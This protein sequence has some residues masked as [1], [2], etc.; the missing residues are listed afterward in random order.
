MKLIKFLFG[1]IFTLLIICFV[2]VGVVL[3]LVIDNNFNEPE[4][5]ANSEVVELN[6][7]EV[8]SYGLKDTKNTKK[9]NLSLDEK[10][11]SII[12]KSTAI[13]LN[14]RLAPMGVN[15]KTMYVDVD[16]NNNLKLT[17]YFSVAF[18]NSSL[19]GDLTYELKDG[20]FIFNINKVSVGKISTTMRIITIFSSEEEANRVINGH[21]KDSNM[22]FNINSDSV[23]IS[24]ELSTLKELLLNSMDGN[25]EVG[26]YNAFISLLLRVDNLLGLA[27]EQDKIGVAFDVDRLSLD[28]N[29]DMAIPYTI[30]FKS[31]SD[32]VESLLNNNVITLE[33]ISMV[34][35][36]IVKGYDKLDDES[37]D[38]VKDIDLSSVGINDNTMH[39]GIIDYKKDSVTDIFIDQIKTPFNGFRLTE[40]NWN[41]IL[42]QNDLIGQMSCFARKESDGYK[43]SY[44]SVESVYVD[45]KEDILHLY[46]TLSL[47]GQSIVLNIAI[48]T[49]NSFDLLVEGDIKSAR[50]G[51]IELNEEEIKSILSYLK[52]TTSEQWIIIDDEN[53]KISFD[54]AAVISPNE[55]LQQ[56]VA[57]FGVKMKTTFNKDENGGYVLIVNK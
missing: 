40:E 36:F 52:F 1:L 42:L 3:F 14:E 7:D 27:N 20:N 48:D 33:D 55:K 45:I 2:A 34:A 41:D 53:S 16:E 30:N 12:L 39:E 4:Y 13:K 50:L 8:L 38:K 43:I 24:I 9:L 5:L 25:E 11:L 26:L 35:T 10:D 21:L 56:F 19:K 23:S 46:I 47:N 57:Q 29:R 49:S 15:I 6:F 32:K 37:K 28:T 44:I 22:S 51:D 54:F 31:V 18:I 17:S